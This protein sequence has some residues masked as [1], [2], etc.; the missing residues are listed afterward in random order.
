[1][2]KSK[3]GRRARLR[4]SAKRRKLMPHVMAMYHQLADKAAA[5]EEQEHEEIISQGNLRM[6]LKCLDVTVKD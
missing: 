1:M 5:R 2:G 4:R 6:D 3:A